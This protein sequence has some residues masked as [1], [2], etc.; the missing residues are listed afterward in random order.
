MTQPAAEAFARFLSETGRS[1]ETPCYECFHFCNTEAAANELL[2]LVLCG[3]KA[4]T[5][6]C[7]ACY[8]AEHA[9][10]PVVGSLSVVTDFSGVPA[11]VIE[12]TAVSVLPFCEMTFEVCRREG[13]DNCLDTWRENHKRLFSLEC[14][15]Y[16]RTFHEQMDVVFEDFRVVH[17]F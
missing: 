7:K 9:P 16:G 4:A 12:T 15:D 6:S 3:K 10:L 11:C 2:A 13:E 5:T 8:D 17:R 14:A 1:P